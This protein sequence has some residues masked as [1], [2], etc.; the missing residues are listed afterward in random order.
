MEANKTGVGPS[1]QLT[2]RAAESYHNPYDADAGMIQPT[3]ENCDE[4]PQLVEEE[5]QQLE[6]VEEEGGGVLLLN[7]QFN[8]R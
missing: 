5:Q 7:L 8:Q 6:E 3:S 2:G 4:T 1:N